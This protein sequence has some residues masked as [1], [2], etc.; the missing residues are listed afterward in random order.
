M[1]TTVQASVTVEVEVPCCS[2][3]DANT[4]A[5]QIVKQAMADFDH[6]IYLLNQDSIVDDCKRSSH[7]IKVLGTPKVNMIIV[8]QDAPGR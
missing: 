5:G 1:R 8:Q 2:T 4:T 7:G 6:T 3:W